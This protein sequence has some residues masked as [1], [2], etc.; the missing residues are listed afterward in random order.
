MTRHGIPAL[1]SPPDPSFASSSDEGEERS[2]AVER[3]ERDSAGSGGSVQTAKGWFNRPDPHHLVGIVSL[4][5]LTP[6]QY[7]APVANYGAFQK[8][9]L[10]VSNSAQ[11]VG[12]TF[13]SVV[14]PLLAIANHDLQRRR[15]KL[16]EKDVLTT[17]LLP[18]L[19]FV[20][21]YFGAGLEALV[22]NN[23]YRIYCIE[24]ETNGSSAWVG[25]GFPDILICVK[26]SPKLVCIHIETKHYA[27]QLSRSNLGQ[28][29]FG[30]RGLT[31]AVRSG[32][33]E[34]RMVDGDDDSICLDT[35]LFNIFHGVFLR[36]VS[37][38]TTEILDLSGA[39][40]ED[41]LVALIEGHQQALL[42]SAREEGGGDD[43]PGSPDGDSHS[44]RGEDEDRFKNSPAKKRRDA[45]AAP[46]GSKDKKVA[47]A[48]TGSGL[49]KQ[50][51]GIVFRLAGEYESHAAFDSDCGF[52]DETMWPDIEDLEWSSDV[53]EIENRD[54]N[55][56]AKLAKT[57]RTGRR[58]QFEDVNPLPDGQAASADHEWFA[59]PSGIW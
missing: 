23:T 51:Q 45:N 12:E 47:G 56:A 50:H 43:V 46:V 27:N 2:E 15:S 55:A 49:K 44:S 57:E 38:A 26:G 40:A 20:C 52:V 13:R 37:E 36:C 35:V 11:L 42:R 33:W 4:S 17:F 59:P 39:A 6:S 41:V 29:L 30:G 16:S 31:R 10:D 53:D 28:A 18:W 25:N 22:D 8:K 1:P 7:N 34:A 24:T 9:G 48:G 54:I 32:Q 14:R 58:P 21:R 3:D 5:K 19:N